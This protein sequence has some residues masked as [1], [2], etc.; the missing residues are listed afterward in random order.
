MSTTVLSIYAMHA[1]SLRITY[2]VEDVDEEE[3]E[4]DE[5]DFED[6]I[7][8]LVVPPSPLINTCNNSIVLEF[9]I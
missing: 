9:N 5:D 1:P 3:V 2:R 8:E 7:Q 6:D 4:E